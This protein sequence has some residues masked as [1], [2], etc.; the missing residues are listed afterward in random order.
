MSF[1][2]FIFSDTPSNRL[3]FGLLITACI[4]VGCLEDFDWGGTSDSNIPT[5]VE[6]EQED[7]ACISECMEKINETYICKDGEWQFEKTDEWN[8]DKDDWDEEER[9]WD[10]DEERDRDDDEERDREDDD[11]GE[12]SATVRMMKSATEKSMSE[13]I[14]NLNAKTA[15]LWKKHPKTPKKSVPK[16]ARH[17]KRAIRTKRNMKIKMRTCVNSKKN[18]RMVMRRPAA[19]CE[20]SLSSWRTKKAMRT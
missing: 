12:E 10:D 20:S 5:E 3:L 15:T 4:S 7:D 9:D 8:E 18:V 13:M 14:G 17:L 1:K 11:E 6:T 2:K 19:N 16:N